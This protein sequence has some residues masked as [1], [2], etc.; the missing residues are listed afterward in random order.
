MADEFI[1][2]SHSPY[3]TLTLPKLLASLL[4]NEVPLKV[5]YLIKKKEGSRVVVLRMDSVC[6]K[7]LLQTAMAVTYGKLQEFRSWLTGREDGPCSRGRWTAGDSNLLSCSKLSHTANQS[8]L[9][10]SSHC[11]ARLLVTGT[12]TVVCFYSEA[13]FSKAYAFLKH[14]ENTDLKTEVSWSPYQRWYFCT[15]HFESN[16]VLKKWVAILMIFFKVTD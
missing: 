7:K 2:V 4:L 13:L 10:V 15:K 16:V 3:D 9:L 6:L 11:W 14:S 5:W 8:V 1:T 12:I